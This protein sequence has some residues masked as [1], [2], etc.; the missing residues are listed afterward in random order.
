MEKQSIS[1][2]SKL[3]LLAFLFITISA[4]IAMGKF[5]AEGGV[6]DEARPEVEKVMIIQEMM[7][8]GNKLDELR[9]PHQQQPNNNV[10]ANAYHQ[11]L[12]TSR[13]PNGLKE[14]MIAYSIAQ[15]MG[16]LQ[17]MAAGTRGRCFMNLQCCNWYCELFFNQPSLCH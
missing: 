16:T 6:S 9:R 12:M 7:E 11:Q 5:Q 2:T 8:Q 1:S 10:N 13:N 15:Q 14:A 3:A 4:P 17:C